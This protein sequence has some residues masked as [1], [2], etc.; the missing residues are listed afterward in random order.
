MIHLCIYGFLVSLDYLGKVQIIGSPFL[1]KLE[2]SGI[3]KRMEGGLTS[4][5]KYIAIFSSSCQLAV[6]LERDFAGER[7]SACV[8]ERE[9]EMSYR[10]ITFTYES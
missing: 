9:R 4:S 3:C 7:K 10:I 1:L 5:F 8:S 2:K 6:D